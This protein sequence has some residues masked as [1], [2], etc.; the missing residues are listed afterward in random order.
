MPFRLVASIALVV[1]SSGLVAAQKVPAALPEFGPS[2][3]I[4]PGIRLQE[5][6]LRR[7]AVPMRV[8]FY[9]PE[10]AA[11]KLPLVLV[12]PAGST[13]F[14]GMAL[15]EGD[16]SEH[17]PYV[18]AGF[19][20][21]AFDIDGDVP[22]L[23]NATEA[24]LLKGAKAFRDSQAG[25]ANAK[26]ALDFILAKAPNINPDRIY[27]AGHS[28]AAT[29]AL[30]VAENEPRI[31]ACAAYAPCTDVEMRLAKITPQLDKAIPGY[32]KFI[33]SSSPKTQTDKLKCPVFLFHAQDDQNVPIRETTDFAKLLKKINP[34]VTLVT[35]RTGGHHD[36]M[37]REG[38]PKAIDW[39]R[40]LPKEKR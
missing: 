11:G 22:N 30:L 19:A 2:R 39:F 1:F 29:L 4:Q 16:R 5:V 27:V 26:A 40:K 25:L 9:Q 32:A 3:R 34:R 21:A 6:T 14:V 8:W 35:A 18:K 24:T 10:K 36:S 12:P 20:V 13:L 28:S 15:S 31:K 33:R 23:E 7:D 37:V 38:V 17:Y